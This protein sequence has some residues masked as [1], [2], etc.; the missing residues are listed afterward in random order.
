MFTSAITTP[1]QEQRLGRRLSLM[2]LLRRLAV[3]LALLGFA[4]SGWA[5]PTQMI[6]LPAGF[7]WADSSRTSVLETELEFANTVG[8]TWQST[9]FGAIYVMEE[10]KP[11]FSR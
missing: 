8:K 5:L 7:G 6:S 3:L 9:H 10:S 4:S 2:P 11:V 1:P